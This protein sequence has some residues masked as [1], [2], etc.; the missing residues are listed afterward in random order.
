MQ[1]LD[2]T[3]RFIAQIVNAAIDGRRVS[4]PGRNIP[5]HPEIE[6]RRGIGGLIHGMLIALLVIVQRVTKLG[7]FIIDSRYVNVIIVNWRGHRYHGQQVVMANVSWKILKIKLNFIEFTY[8]LI[9]ILRLTYS[10][11]KINTYL[12]INTN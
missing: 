2:S 10:T 1:S 6:N 4:C 9:E 5:G 8:N 12:G 3:H 11:K 7:H